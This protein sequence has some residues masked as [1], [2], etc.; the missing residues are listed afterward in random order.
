MKKITQL[1]D[2]ALQASEFGEYRK[3]FFGL[4]EIV[5]KKEQHFPVTIPGRQQVSLDDKLDL[6]TWMRVLSI[7]E[8]DAPEMSYGR[9]IRTRSTAQIRFVVA[10]K[11]DLPDAEELILDISKAIPFYLTSSGYKAIF[12]L[13][14]RPIN[15]DHEGIY[16]EEL[17]ATAYS[18]HRLTWNLYAI[19][20]NVQFIL[21]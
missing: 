1:I 13:K 19:T 15:N 21:C 9:N 8:E 2:Q 17:D 14:T 11:T 5:T 7:N 10:L 4:S 20:L 6:I 16:Q 12:V 18:K 3:R